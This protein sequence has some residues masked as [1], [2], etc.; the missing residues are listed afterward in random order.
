ME[1]EKIILP[2]AF[3]LEE[4]K[5]ILPTA[6]KLDKHVKRRLDRFIHK[7]ESAKII[8]WLGFPIIANLFFIYLLNKYKSKCLLL[9]RDVYGI[10]YLGI[11]IY[12]NNDIDNYTL[13]ASEKKMF[14]K[15][16]IELTKC[17]ER[18]VETILIPLR[19]D[20]DSADACHSNILIYRK[21]ENVIEH[22]EP[23]GKIFMY[24][25][26]SD[27]ISSKLKTF[28]SMLNTELKMKGM[29]NKVKFITASRVCPRINGLQSLETEVKDTILDDKESESGGYCMAWSLFFAELALQNPTISSNKLLTS[30]LKMSKF[31]STYIRNIIRGYVLNINEKLDKYFSV[32]YGDKVSLEKLNKT[33]T[34]NTFL[35]PDFLNISNFFEAVMKVEEHKLNPHFNKEEYIR[36]L[37]RE[38]KEKPELY[39]IEI[40]KFELK[41][42]KNIN[43]LEDTSQSASVSPAT[44]SS[45]PKNKTKKAKPTREPELEPEPESI[46][47]LNDC[48]EGKIRNPKTGRCVKIKKT[49]K[50]T[51]RTQSR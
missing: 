1:E 34:K 37:E 12:I 16:I 10:I 33:L 30:V 40:K 47:A 19:I 23:H 45:K 36:E 48:P 21:N 41:I 11:T 42:I 29:P 32:L 43:I 6:Y 44:L 31:N 24:E 4:D 8:K 46:K 2:T 27:K 15:I 35:N 17:I 18:G 20:R 9:G 49:K 3:K 7:I 50:S 5:I 25:S 28:V 14:N 51:T 38:I 26:Y 39:R 13:N 22:F